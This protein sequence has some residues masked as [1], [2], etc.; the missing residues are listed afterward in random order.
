MIG[1]RNCVVTGSDPVERKK[2]REGKREKE[3]EGKEEGEI[4]SKAQKE[5][6]TKD[7]SQTHAQHISLEL[8]F[9]LIHAKSTTTVLSLPEQSI[10]KTNRATCTHILTITIAY[11][12]DYQ[13]STLTLLKKC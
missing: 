10:H 11:C 13:V 6:Y 7:M 5:I 3:R 4:E 8:P 12:Y 2:G 9:S 1:S